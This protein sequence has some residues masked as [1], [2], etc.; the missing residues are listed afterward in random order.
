M[1]I[2]KIGR[3]GFDIELD[4]PETFRQRARFDDAVI[5]L[6]GDLVSGSLAQTKALREELVSQAEMGFIVPVTW[7]GDARLDG[8]YEVLSVDVN[9]RTLTDAGYAEFSISLKR[10]GG[11][12]GDVLQESQLTFAL[13]ANP[14]G[15]TTSGADTMIGI[16]LPDWYDDGVS[17]PL[18]S[19]TFDVLSPDGTGNLVD[20]VHQY[21][22]DGISGSPGST[23]VPRWRTPIDEYY[24]GA[25]QLWVESRLIAGRF[26]D[27]A[28]TKDVTL[29][30]KDWYLTNGIIRFQPNATTLSRFDLDLWGQGDMPGHPPGVFAGHKFDFKT[31]PAGGNAE[32]ASTYTPLDLIQTL[33]VLENR[34]EVVSV[35]FTGQTEGS[36]FRFYSHEVTMRRGACFVVGRTIYTGVG[37]LSEVGFGI[38]SSPAELALALTGGMK[39]SGT[40]GTDDQWMISHADTVHT[41]TTD[42]TLGSAIFFDTTNPSHTEIF[43][44]VL[45]IQPRDGTGP[46]VNVAAQKIEDKYLM[47]TDEVV[48]TMRA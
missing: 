4:H 33:E 41:I 11:A 48:R 5:I 17:A 29:G 43:H 20:A 38:F 44:W 42:L 25:A 34:P 2:L 13:R 1:A 18:S 39:R 16:N 14:H 32:T 46:W 47:A 31:N 19:T 21:R 45:G 10:F 9:T 36:P 24:N 35:R 8:F 6:S 3:V 40:S 23:S 30:L 7:T 26:L 37:A 15:V 12:L 28:L 22:G 27:P